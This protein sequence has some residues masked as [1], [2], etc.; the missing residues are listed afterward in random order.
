MFFLLFKPNKQC[1]QPKAWLTYVFNSWRYMVLYCSCRSRWNCLFERCC[2]LQS[3]CTF[4][5]L[6]M[7]NNLLKS[8]AI[9][10]QKQSIG[11]KLVCFVS[12]VGILGCHLFQRPICRRTRKPMVTWQVKGSARDGMSNASHHSNSGV[13]GHGADHVNTRHQPLAPL[14]RWE[15]PGMNMQNVLV[16]RPDSYRV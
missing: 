8:R 4:K 15:W 3:W 6:T 1:L 13:T 7:Y 9:E 14:T 12:S 11:Y 16:K 2:Q 10:L 5:N